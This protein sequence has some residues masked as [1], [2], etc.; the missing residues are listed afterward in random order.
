MYLK[1]LVFYFFLTAFAYGQK[2]IYEVKYAFEIAG[3]SKVIVDCVLFHYVEDRKSSFLNLG[4][5]ELPKEKKS[6]NTN[7]EGTTFIEIQQYD[8]GKDTLEYQKDFLAQKL[9][10]F[11]DVYGE[12]HPVIVQ[13]KLPT[14]KWSLIGETSKMLG[15]TVQK[16]KVNFRGRT[17]T[18]WFTTEINVSDGP[19]KFHGLPGLILKIASDDGY[20]SFEAYSVKSVVQQPNYSLVPLTQ[21]YPKRKTLT[22][23]AMLKLEQEN[24]EKERRFLLSRES[25]VTSV[26]IERN[27]IELNY[28]DIE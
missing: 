20:Y 16:A 11:A 23:Q 19:F 18:A 14:L 10:A 9:D 7:S 2:N 4:F 12:E 1:L 28:D 15:F 24:L 8:N 21:K 13:E 5:R 27:G 22:I 3:D 26:K 6:E 25:N 17:Y